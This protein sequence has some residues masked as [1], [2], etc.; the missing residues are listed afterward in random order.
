[1]GG[2]LTVDMY[3]HQEVTT[4]AKPFVEYILRCNWKGDAGTAD[5]PWLVNHRYSEFETL[6]TKIK[7]LLEV[8]SKSSG[9][10]LP[11]LPGKSLFGGAKV[12]EERRVGLVLYL[13]QL[14]SGFPAL[15][16]DTAVDAFF[17]FKQRLA[18]VLVIAKERRASSG[19]FSPPPAP[20][21]R[22]AGFGSPP[23]VPH[24]TAEPLTPLDLQELEASILSLSQYIAEADPLLNDPR[25][26]EEVQAFVRCVRSGLVRLGS[27]LEAALLSADEST[28]QRL[29]KAHEDAKRTLQE[30][31][32][33]VA[34][35]W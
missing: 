19:A 13:K 6:H 34:R 35:L 29:L 24:G 5:V 18:S 1:M 25:G 11:K 33:F 32:T 12:V 31:D 27:T 14:F 4:E 8:I 16:E 3:G 26:S 9:A 2:H 17:Q 30:Y 28:T 15:L 10:P 21:A 20:A 23:A 7:S 22:A